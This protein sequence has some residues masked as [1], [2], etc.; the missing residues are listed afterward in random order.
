MT[1]HGS[2][3][4][5]SS[6]SSTAARSPPASR[7][8][9]AAASRRSATWGSSRR[10]STRRSSRRCRARSRSATRATRRPAAHDWSNAQ[11]LVHHGAART[12]ALGHNGNLVDPASLRDEL[13]ADGVPARLDVRHRGD[14]RA[15]RPRPGAAPRG[16]RA[17][18]ERLEGAY[19]I[20]AIADGDARRV[21]RPTRDPAA[22]RS[23]GSATTGSSRPRRA[24]STSS[25]PR[26]SAT[27]SRAR[28]SG[29]TRTAATRRRPSRAAAAPPASS[30][31]ST[32]RGRTPTSA[33]PASTRRACGW[34]SGSP[35]RRP[36]RP[37]S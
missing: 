28:S 8:P 16:C 29:S 5:A 36:S 15:A 35:R 19:S 30:S 27:S 25:A 37:T 3:T 34:A 13:L 17:D 12:V 14:R 23:A 26:S 10:S 21:P 24:R 11:P 4:S 6:R 9:R 33:A 20:V 2:R 32:S 18:D 7:S 1:S 22:R 31:T